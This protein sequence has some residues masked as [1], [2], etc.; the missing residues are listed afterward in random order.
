MQLPTKTFVFPLG[1]IYK[2]ASHR[3]DLDAYYEVLLQE[4]LRYRAGPR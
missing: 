2:T 3:D 1:K 4:K